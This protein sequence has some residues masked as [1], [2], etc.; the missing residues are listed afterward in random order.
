VTI[1]MPDLAELAAQALQRPLGQFSP[2]KVVQPQSLPAAESGS[3]GPAAIC[4][5]SIPLITIVALFV[6]NLFLPIVTFAFGLWFLLAFK[7]C[8]PPAVSF[9]AD[10]EAKLDAAP[11]DPDADFAATATLPSGASVSVDAG[12]LNADLHEGIRKRFGL[13]AEATAALG[14]LSN[15]PLADLAGVARGLDALPDAA[16]SD[17]SVRDVTAGLAYEPRR[18]FR[19]A[20]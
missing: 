19:G 11:P 13:G 1:Q 8:L 20:A 6:F 14:A 18:R 2:V 4:F 15:R 7:F 10:L 16:A 5:L 17:P 9:S 12:S 3:I